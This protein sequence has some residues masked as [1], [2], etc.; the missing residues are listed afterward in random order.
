MTP[1][2]SRSASDLVSA[3]P[4]YDLSSRSRP[5]DRHRRTRPGHRMPTPES[6][7]GASAPAW[8]AF[9][10]QDQPASPSDEILPTHSSLTTRVEIPILSAKPAAAARPSAQTTTATL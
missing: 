8:T 3:I 2:M 10:S 9:T 5:C 4:Y 6:P 1:H 7:A